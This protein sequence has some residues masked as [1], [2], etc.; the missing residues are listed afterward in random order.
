MASSF[1]V[2]HALQ[3]YVIPRKIVDVLSV[4]MGLSNGSVGPHSRKEITSIMVGVPITW[5]TQPLCLSGN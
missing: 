5:H 4:V 1:T 3:Q 2:D